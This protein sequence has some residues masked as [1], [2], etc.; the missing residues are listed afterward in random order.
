M[1]DEW[2]MGGW[3]VGW[4]VCWLI[5]GLTWFRWLLGDWMIEN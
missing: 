4:L 1:V 2:L 3:L 5:D